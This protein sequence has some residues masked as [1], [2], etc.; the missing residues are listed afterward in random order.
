[1]VGGRA[2]GEGTG[3][4]E[5]LACLT[6]DDRAAETQAAHGL[7]GRPELHEPLRATEA[8]LKTQ[9][10]MPVPGELRGNTEPPLRSGG[11]QPTCLQLLIC[12][13]PPRPTQDPTSMEG[14]PLRLRKSLGLN[15]P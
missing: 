11:P 13:T 12:Q 2:C 3:W 5:P 8:P 4:P 6:L 1:M 10:G 7:R 15:L 14:E 9:T